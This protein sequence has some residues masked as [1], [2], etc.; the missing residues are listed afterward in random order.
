MR[1]HLLL[2]E[3]LRKRHGKL[4]LT[5]SIALLDLDSL[6]LL[7][8]DKEAARK[9]LARLVPLM[10]PLLS[11]FGSSQQEESPLLASIAKKVARLIERH[12]VVERH[13][14]KFRRCP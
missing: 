14:R 8:Q 6:N 9:S 4:N 13:D 7:P 1:K 11:V 3:Q 2:E 10:K 12:Q 5:P